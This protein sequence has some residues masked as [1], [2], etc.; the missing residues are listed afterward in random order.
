MKQG[1]SVLVH[2]RPETLVRFT[3]L[4]YRRGYRLESLDL[5]QADQQ[6]MSTITAVVEGADSTNLLHHIRKL[7]EVVR[8]EHAPCGE[9]VLQ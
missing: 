8:V 5:S 7:V 6:G 3:G 9:A 2:H 1:L 4:L